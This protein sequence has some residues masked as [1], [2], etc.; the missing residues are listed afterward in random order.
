MTGTEALT[1]NDFLPL[2]GV[3]IGGVLAIAGGF[4]STLWLE[5]RRESKQ[6]RALAL[7][8]QGEIGALLE[9]IEKR[10]YI[11]GLRETRAET[12]A[13]GKTQGFYFRA[14]RGY[15]SVFDANVSQIGILKPPLSGLVARFYTQANSILEDMERFEEA[16]PADVDPK[17]AIQAYDELIILF[18]DVVAVGRQI[19][20]EVSRLYS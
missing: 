6:R 18:E 13:T 5:S 4:V 3:V 19:V 14:R 8:F 11:E 20:K 16:K 7:A 12:E 9:I 2:A 15:F 10:G 1:I 17:V